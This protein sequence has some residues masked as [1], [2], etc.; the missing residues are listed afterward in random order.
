MSIKIVL[1][2]EIDIACDECGSYLEHDENRN[3]L[4]MNVSDV[5][6]CRKCLKEKYD[7]GYKDGLEENK[8]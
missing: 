4:I 8:S 7:E 2:H 3:P 1:E 6:P 5:K